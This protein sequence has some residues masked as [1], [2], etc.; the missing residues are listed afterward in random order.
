MATLGYDA[1][2][3]EPARWLSGRHLVSLVKK[4]LEATAAD[5]A[6]GYVQHLK[7]GDVAFIH[8]HLHSSNYSV[9]RGCL[10]EESLQPTLQEAGSVLPLVGDFTYVF[11]KT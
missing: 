7:I 6:P 1:F 4:P 5:L 11:L 9:L 10:L 3:W 8:L 2:I